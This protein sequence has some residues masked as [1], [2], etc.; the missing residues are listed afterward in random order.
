M[1]FTLMKA[2]R[3]IRLGRE[4]IG[5]VGYYLYTRVIS[6]PWRSIRGVFIPNCGQDLIAVKNWQP[7]NLINYLGKFVEKVV[8]DRMRDFG[9]E[10]FHW[11]Q[12][13]SVRGRSALDVLYKLMRQGH[14]CI[15]RGGRMWREFSYDKGG[16]QNV[17]GDGVLERLP[18]VA[19]RKGLRSWVKH[20]VTPREFE[21]S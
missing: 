11:L 9:G 1:F 3:D 17:I 16:F 18:G 19:G 15:D 7:I 8:A 6:K 21:L 12:Y 14:K 10:L 13:G 5:E 4:L 2:V 20:F